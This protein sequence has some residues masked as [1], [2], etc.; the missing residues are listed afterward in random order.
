M[1]VGPVVGGA[2]HRLRGIPREVLVD[3]VRRISSEL[4]ADRRELL[5]RPDVAGWEL[6]VGL[7]RRGTQDHAAA[8]VI[9][10]EPADVRSGDDRPDERVDLGLRQR[11]VTRTRHLGSPARREVA[12][13]VESFGSRRRRHVETVEVLDR[14]FGEHAVP[15]DVVADAGR[16]HRDH[17]PIVIGVGDPRAVGVREPHLQDAAVAVDVLLVEARP[18]VRVGER[19]RA[20]TR[21]AEAGA[22]GEDPL[23]AVGVDARDHVE[24]ARAQRPGD[25]G[26][27]G[28]V[29]VDEALEQPTRGDRR[30]QFHGVDAGVD[31]VRR[32]GVVR[33]GGVVRDGH[34]HQIAPLERPSIGLDGHQ[35]GVSGSELIDPGDQFVVAQEPVEVV[36]DHAGRLRAR[37]TCAPC[38]APSARIG[39]RID[40]RSTPR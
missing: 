11:V 17:Q 19:P 14:A 10:V 26:V 25:G 28:G 24:R 21:A 2:A 8:G 12:V 3:R 22:V 31:P 20:H 34:E 18:A 39:S 35:I 6:R 7:R 33:P 32:L 40:G 9:R 13:E 5:P 30:G 16:R 37:R 4:G 27:A 29:P 38:L 1:L 15:G 23:G 36:V